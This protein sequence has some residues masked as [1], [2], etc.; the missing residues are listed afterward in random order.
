MITLFACNINNFPF[1]GYNSVYPVVLYLL[2][3]K[4][5]D[6]YKQQYT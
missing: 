1:D 4:D 3:C 2:L 5:A 6:F